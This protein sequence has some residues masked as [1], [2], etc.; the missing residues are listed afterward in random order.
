MQVLPQALPTEQTLQQERD[1]GVGC[2]DPRVIRDCRS[3]LAECARLNT[4]ERQSAVGFG[5]VSE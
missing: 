1:T 2:A 3:G 4:V 5:G